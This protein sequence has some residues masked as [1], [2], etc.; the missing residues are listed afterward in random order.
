M[1]YVNK[2]TIK[3]FV[4]ADLQPINTCGITSRNVNKNRQY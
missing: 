2:V 3:A 4:Y 1:L